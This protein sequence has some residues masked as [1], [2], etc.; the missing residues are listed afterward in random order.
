MDGSD[1]G[2]GTAPSCRDAAHE[3]RSCDAALARAFSFLGK[4]WNG[5][6]LGVLMGG[7]AT[8]GQLRRAVAGISDSVLS[9]RLS[10]LT[11]VGLVARTVEDGPPVGVTYR[12]TD[13]GAALSPALGE[14]A[15][16][17]AANLSPDGSPGLGC[18]AADEPRRGARQ[19]GE[20]PQMAG[21][22]DRSGPPHPV[23][24]STP[25]TSP[26]KHA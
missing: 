2:K 21:P 3:P 5:V 13:A 16:W 8:F 20:A 7:P 6:I 24:L 15:A 18:A 19:R 12:L 22:D 23:P 14:L 26:A 9:D 10:E 11:G 17:A 4:R 25:A 1:S